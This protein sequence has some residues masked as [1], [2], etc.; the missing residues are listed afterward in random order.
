MAVLPFVFP[1]CAGDESFCLS[2]ISIVALTLTESG[3]MCNIYCIIYFD[4]QFL[5]QNGVGSVSNLFEKIRKEYATFSPQH[6]LLAEEILSNA[7]D[8]AFLTA[9]QLGDRLGISS[10]TVVRFAHRL[11]FE[12]YPE[13]RK[14]VQKVFCDENVPMRKLRESFEGP[15]EAV[16]VFADVCACDQENIAA[17]A[18]SG[19]GEGLGRAVDMLLE[20]RTVVFLGGRS[21]YSLVHYAGFLLRQLDTKFTFFNACVDD[22]YERLEERGRNDVVFAISFHRYY[23]RTL[24]LVAFVRERDIPIISLTDS[25]RSPLAPLASVLLLAPNRAPFYSYVVPMVILNG[26][27]AAYAKK[28]HLSSREIFLQRSKTLLEKGIYV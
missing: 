8:L 25:L 10:A 23:R 28:V 20:A 11:G 17:V 16:D 15:K 2:R 13:L 27:V 19:I 5:L 18:S 1:V 24:E 12:G 22:A 6:R 14:E 21:S 3:T 4:L 26:I 7:A 9:K